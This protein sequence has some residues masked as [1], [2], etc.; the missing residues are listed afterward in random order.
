MSGA[1]FWVA[2]QSASS[3]AFLLVRGHDVPSRGS[4]PGGRQVRTVREEPL[5]WLPIDFIDEDAAYHSV[6]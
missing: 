1:A 6:R 3:D 5:E 2:Q 4:V